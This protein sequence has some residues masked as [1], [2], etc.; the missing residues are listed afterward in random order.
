MATGRSR[1]SQAGVGAE[2]WRRGSGDGEL[3]T[4]RSS[5]VGAARD[6]DAD[7]GRRAAEGAGR[8]APSKG[9][10]AEQDADER[11]PRRSRRRAAGAGGDGAGG[12]LAAL[13]GGRAERVGEEDDAR[14]G[15]AWDG[16]RFGRVRSSGICSAPVSQSLKRLTVEISDP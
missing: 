3:A 1:R 4:G 7:E 9:D 12:G 6:A 5:G 8:S 14:G 15:G 11:L 13:D 2:Q 10:G 16:K